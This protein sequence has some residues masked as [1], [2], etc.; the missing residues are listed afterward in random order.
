MKH[1]FKEPLPGAMNVFIN[2]VIASSCL[3]G[4]LACGEL[5]HV[6]DIKVVQGDMTPA[7]VDWEPP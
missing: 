5:V 2:I 7:E 3:E 6:S 4:K 1:F